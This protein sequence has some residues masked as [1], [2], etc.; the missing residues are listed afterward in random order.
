MFLGCIF[1]I[2]VGSLY[3]FFCSLLIILSNFQIVGKEYETTQE[4]YV[5]PTLIKYL[6]ILIFFSKASEVVN[7]LHYSVIFVVVEDIY[8]VHL[9]EGTTCTPK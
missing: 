9:R 3:R 8:V 1:G 6:P 2:H 5:I 7:N 4:L